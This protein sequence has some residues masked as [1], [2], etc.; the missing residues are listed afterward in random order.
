MRYNNL[1]NISI[2]H[3][4]IILYSFKLSGNFRYN[5][6]MKTALTS[7]FREISER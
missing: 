6:V 5:N 7:I 2:I 1:Y 4:E 3:L